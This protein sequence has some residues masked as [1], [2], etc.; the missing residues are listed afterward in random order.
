MIDERH[1]LK[2]LSA[3]FEYGQRLLWVY[4]SRE[5][6]DQNGEVITGNDRIESLWKVARGENGQWKI[7][8]IEEHP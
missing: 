4:Y 3:H 2:L 6:L 8:D 5:G 1:I 7:Y